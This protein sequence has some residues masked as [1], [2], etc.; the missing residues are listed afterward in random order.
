MW[1][2]LDGGDS[3]LTR[4]EGG[5]APSQADLEAAERLRELQ[6][7]ELDR[8]RARASKWRDGL[9]ALGALFGTVLVIKGRATVDGLATWVRWCI[10]SA[11]L[12]AIAAVV[13]S[14]L[15]AML[16]AFGWMS[17]VTSADMAVGLHDRLLSQDR[18]EALVAIRRLKYAAGLTIASIAAVTVAV[19]LSFFGPEAAKTGT[20]MCLTV[21]SPTGGRTVVKMVGT[22]QTIDVAAGATLQTGPC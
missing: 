19:G 20:P 17:R 13:V 5:P 1:P 6:G 3:P 4:I 18:Q 12:V 15:L 2:V 22:K 21:T 7:T 11:L 14:G 8:V 10:G 9:V 16:A